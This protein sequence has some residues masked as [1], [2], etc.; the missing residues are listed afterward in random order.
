MT[1]TEGKGPASGRPRNL[2]RSQVNAGGPSP[3]LKSPITRPPQLSDLSSSGMPDP[4]GVSRIGRDYQGGDHSVTDGASIL[5]KLSKSRSA[6]GS[7]AHSPSVSVV[8]SVIYDS[9]DKI[10]SDVASL[11]EDNEQR[12]KRKKKK[13][14]QFRESQHPGGAKL[15]EL[16]QMRSGEWP[17]GAN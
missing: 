7:R 5:T 15:V 14:I 9:D 10:S 2:A 11:F 3:F 16:R 12:R 6:Q 13:G 1:Q 4:S 17:V 8:T